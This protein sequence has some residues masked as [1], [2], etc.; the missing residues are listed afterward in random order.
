METQI[1]ISNAINVS[2]ARNQTEGFGP[3]S[4]KVTCLISTEEAEAIFKQI[5]KEGCGEL[6]L[7]VSILSIESGDFTG[8][9]MFFQ[10]WIAGLRSVGN[11][12]EITFI[13]YPNWVNAQK[14]RSEALEDSIR[15][16][17][18]TDRE[19]FEKIEM[20]MKRN[21]FLQNPT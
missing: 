14:A 13:G 2:V 6:F 20:D 8:Q 10:A 7:K 1:K 9:K 19:S 17:M 4:C 16:S 15:F 18:Q 5:P 12:A 3:F 11:D 21:W